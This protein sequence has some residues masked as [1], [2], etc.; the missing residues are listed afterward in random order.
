VGH[1]RARA[2]RRRAGDTVHFG[3]ANIAASR[4]TSGGRASMP[5]L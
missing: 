3:V 5:R 4:T 1:L 2:L